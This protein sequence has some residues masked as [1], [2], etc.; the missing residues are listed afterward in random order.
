[1]TL[2]ETIR[3]ARAGGEVQAAVDAIPYA[4]F[5]GI[6][7]EI[8]A[9]GRLLCTL[10]PRQGLVGNPHAAA[11]HGGVVGAFLET[12]AALELLWR[13]ETDTM[14]RTVNITVDYL[15]AARVA[16]THARGIITK[17]GRRVANVR[18]EAWQEDPAK[19]AA[20]GHVHLLLG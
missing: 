9:E 17:L 12:V 16:P 8:D 15:R 6:T 20:H 2:M 4:V 5:L 11:L 10:P 3:E 14:P 7:A 19:P 18:V 1:M 13:R